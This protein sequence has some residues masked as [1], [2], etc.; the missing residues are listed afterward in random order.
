M[1]SVGLGEARGGRGSQ[2][3]GVGR[4]DVGV[5]SSYGVHVLVELAGI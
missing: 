3:D 2:V 1:G 4:K 5:V